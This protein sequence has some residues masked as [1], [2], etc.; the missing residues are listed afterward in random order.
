MEEF[1]TKNCPN[2]GLRLNIENKQKTIVCPACD[3]SFA[4]S[5]LLNQDVKENAVEESMESLAQ[6]VVDSEGGLIYLKNC[7]ENYDW[8]TFGQTTS[9]KV[10]GV[11]EMVE[12]NKIKFANNPNTYVLEFESIYVPVL[13]K[14]EGL[15]AIA[16]TIA[17]KYNGKDD[18]ASYEQFDTYKK[19]LNALVNQKSKLLKV[20]Q[21][22][23]TYAENLKL[24]EEKLQ[25]LK[26]KLN[27]LQQKLNELKT[28]A[29]LEDIP[30]VAQTI[31]KKEEE[32]EKE[33]LKKG[34]NAKEVYKDALRNYEQGQ[35][36]AAL[37]LF[38]SVVEYKDSAKYMKK[39]N[40]VYAFGD[41]LVLG[42]RTF[43]VKQQDK[44]LFNVSSAS[45]D[46]KEQKAEADSTNK[47]NGC[48]CSSIVAKN[49]NTATPNPEET[50]EIESKGEMYSIYQI[51]DG[52]AEKEPL[53]KDIS[54]LLYLYGS[55]LYYIQKNKN[56]CYYN[57]EK[58]EE[59]VLDA[60]N[61]AEYV[62]VNNDSLIYITPDYTS[63]V[64]KKQLELKESP[65]QKGCALF[66]KPQ[67]QTVEKNNNFS[68]VL[69]DMRTA[70][71]KTLVPEVVDVMDIFEDEVFYTKASVVEKEPAKK[72]CF[73]KSDAVTE[74]ITEFF[75]YNVKTGV[76]EQILD[77][78]SVLF[79][80]KCDKLVYAKMSPNLYNMNLYALDLRTKENVLLEDNM[81]DF[82]NIIDNK[83]YY[84][85]GNLYYRPLYS[86]NLDGTQ[87][88]EIMQ[89]IDKINAIL[90]GWMYVEKGY[91]MNKILMKISAD[92]KKRVVLCQNFASLVKMTNGFVYY[93]DR[94]NNLV[95]VRS[96]GTDYH[97]IAKG[98]SA[99][100]V[101]VEKDYIYY[102]R[103]ET[104][105]FDEKAFG[106]RK[107]VYA[108]S[109]Y[110]MDLDG[111]NI[112]KLAFNLNGMKDFD[113]DMLYFYK[114]E[115][116]TFKV[117]KPVEKNGVEV[118]V[119][120]YDVVRYMSFNKQTNETKVLFT[121]GLPNEEHLLMK[122]GCF[123]KPVEKDVEF[124]EI[125]TKYVFVRKNKASIGSVYEEQN[126]EKDN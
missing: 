17:K 108:N 12:K 76:N 84:T 8:N 109:L 6:S 70:T 77:E 81:Y 122:G 41:M 21:N 32:A 37:A 52:K 118:S 74:V 24:E 101:I 2:C 124:E 27:Q 62:A 88:T 85:I 95:M 94:Q 23:V 20:L 63:L 117:K 29:K 126:K 91:G 47:K 87:R 75:A 19:V 114:N 97:L 31:A 89:N 105:D 1:V 49:N 121:V 10:Y 25:E 104:V 79:D 119:K 46:A 14:M 107:E 45:K 51:K 55:K 3:S 123:K 30:V 92:G 64:M 33:L 100:N 42:D 120:E 80:V 61:G 71:L 69:I 115:T 110:R 93:V 11:C 40:R 7:F 60:S 15:V 35:K 43:F 78:N 125:P 58:N 113:E 67:T 112:K 106:G 66:K 53:I 57:L 16:N 5:E 4:V 98:I 38:Q 90:Y 18:T 44:A 82:F 39:I 34:V 22:D 111:H 72:G 54:V 59:V 83:V 48:G 73:K 86:I 102:L 68:V 116:L 103:R 28:V 96:D 36:T 99:G 26:E 9:L 13:K 50:P 56:L 65:V